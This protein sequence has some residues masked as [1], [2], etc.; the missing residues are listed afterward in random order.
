MVDREYWARGECRT[1]DD[2]DLSPIAEMVRQTNETTPME[3]QRHAVP[4]LSG[5]YLCRGE[6]CL[7]R[8]VKT[9]RL[10]FIDPDG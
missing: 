4:V 3:R 2:A 1:T 9:S 7:A 8:F 10:A 6:V 5:A